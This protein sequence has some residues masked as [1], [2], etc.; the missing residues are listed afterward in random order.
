[1]RLL[2]VALTGLTLAACQASSDGMPEPEFETNDQKASYAIGLDMGRQIMPAGEHLDLP[3]MIAG[4]QDRL[5]ERDPRFTDEELR[6]VMVTFNEELRAEDEARRAEA[7]EANQAESEA[8]LAENGAKDGVTTTESG[9]QYEVLR[10]GDGP[11]PSADDRVRLHY[12]GTLVDGT[13]FDSSY[14]GD[15]AVF[16]VGGVIPGFSE[17]L[18][19]M[20]VGSHYR[21]AIPGDQAYG[22]TGSGQ[23]IGPDAAL[24]FEIELL[25]IVE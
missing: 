18:Q 17:A 12:R 6:A 20:N 16:S 21:V 7:S 23:L 13:E 19:L 1:M 5:A 22:S 15:P 24:I 11:Q 2:F 9:L 10:Q 4:V 3:A 25:E 8:F 14:E